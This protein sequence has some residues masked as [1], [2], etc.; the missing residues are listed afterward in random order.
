[1]QFQ[2][3]IQHVRGKS[4]FIADTLSR[5]PLKESSNTATA[6]SS[7]TEQFVQAIGAVLSA[8]ANHLEIYSAK[9]VMIE[10]AQNSINFVHLGGQPEINLAENLKNTENTEAVLYSA[11]NYHIKHK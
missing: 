2:Y 5:A 4:L 10:S 9:Q 8:S 7:E 1:M 6:S 3:A 11:T